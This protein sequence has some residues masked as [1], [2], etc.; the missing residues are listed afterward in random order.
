MLD[1]GT[2]RISQRVVPPNVVSPA[3]VTLRSALVCEL[4]VLK[5]AP[6]VLVP[7]PETVILSGPMAM[8]FKLN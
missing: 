2:P 3:N 5:I 1:A 7:D 4:P 8:P 6:L